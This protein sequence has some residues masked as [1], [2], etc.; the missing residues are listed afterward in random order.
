[1]YLTESQPEASHKAYHQVQKFESKPEE[2]VLTTTEVAESS[3]TQEVIIT[4]EPKTKSKRKLNKLNRLKRKKSDKESRRKR[5][6]SDKKEDTAKGVDEEPAFETPAEF[7][8]EGADGAFATELR[9]VYSKKLGLTLPA[10]MLTKSDHE[11]SYD[12]AVASGK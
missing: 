4:P 5:S 12:E 3:V 6:V 2:Q 1:M 9:P 7:D 11:A 10:F 8:V